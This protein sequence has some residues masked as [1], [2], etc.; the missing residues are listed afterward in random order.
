MM[1]S[2]KATE[3]DKKWNVTVA[4][5]FPLSTLLYFSG[6]LEN[7]PEKEG[8]MYTALSVLPKFSEH[9]RTA[10]EANI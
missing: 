8:T 1:G 2:V 9:L 7:T 3:A 5:L 6:T 10:A 4:V